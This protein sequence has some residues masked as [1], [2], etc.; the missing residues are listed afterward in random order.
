MEDAIAAADVVVRGPGEGDSIL[1]G[2]AVFKAQVG[3]GDG[4]FSLSEITLPPGLFGAHRR[5][6]IIPSGVPKPNGPKA[7]CTFYYLKDHT[8]E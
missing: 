8:F 2:A 7:H 4:T 1:G 5:D 3:D 6:F